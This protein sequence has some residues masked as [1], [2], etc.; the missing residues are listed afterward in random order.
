MLKGKRVIAA[1][2]L[3]VILC[4]CAGRTV[5]PEK[6]DF[7]F[8]L[9]DGYA[10]SNVTDKNCSIVRQEDSTVVGGIEV[11]GLKR[12]DLKTAAP[13]ISCCIYRMIS[14]K[15]MTLNT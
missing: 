11:T 12:G 13:I 14:I 6:G 1:A 15:Q 9:P 2:V 3:A 8:D 4:G 5:E 7:S 10:V